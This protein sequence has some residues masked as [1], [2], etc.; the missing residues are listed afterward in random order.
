MVKNQV[1]LLLL[2]FYDLLII[3]N[4]DV[5]WILCAMNLGGGFLIFTFGLSKFL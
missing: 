3:S 4:G 2:F 1:L 5:R